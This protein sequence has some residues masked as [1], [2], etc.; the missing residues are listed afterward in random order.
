M[1]TIKFHGG[2]WHVYIQKLF[3]DIGFKTEVRHVDNNIVKIADTEFEDIIF[4]IQNSKISTNEVEKRNTHYNSCNKNVFWFVNGQDMEIMMLEKNNT[5]TFLIDIKSIWK[6]QKFINC[7]WIYA[8]VLHEG[9][10]YIIKFDPNMVKMNMIYV[11]YI[12]TIDYFFNNIKLDNTDILEKPKYIRPCSL[13]V[14]QYP[15]GSGKTFKMVQNILRPD[16]CPNFNQYDT[17]IILTKPHSAKEVVK[18][19]FESQLKNNVQDNIEVGEHNKGYWYRLRIQDRDILIILA[20]GDSF[21]YSVG[22]KRNYYLDYFK[23]IC[24]TIEEKGPSKLSKNGFTTFKGLGICI[25]AKTLICIDEATK[26]QDYYANALGKLMFYCN[27]DS[28]IIGDLLQS[29]EHEHSLFRKLLE[30]TDP[31][32]HVCKILENGNEIRR[33]GNNLVNFLVNINTV[34]TYNKYNLPRPIKCNDSNIKRDHEGKYE[35]YPKI[36]SFENK[37]ENEDQEIVDFL[38]DKLKE[39]I[40]TLFLLPSDVLCI[41]PFVSNNILAERFRDAL[42]IFWFEQLQDD[43]YRIHMLNSP[44]SSSAN[45]YFEWFDNK[46]LNKNM[47]LSVLHRSESGLP[48][49]TSLSRNSTR[50]VSIHASQ[51]DGRRFVFVVGLSE[52]TLKKFSDNEFN[53]KYDSLLNVACSRAKSECVIIIHKKYDDIFKRFQSFIS[54]SDKTEIKPC[55][56]LTSTIDMNKLSL[57]I[58]NLETDVNVITDKLKCIFNDNIQNLKPLY[59]YEHHVIRNSAYNLIWTMLIHEHDEQNSMDKQQVKAKFKQ[60]SE[61]PVQSFKYQQYYKTLTTYNKKKSYDNK[62]K[63]IYELTCIPVLF[64]SGK[65]YVHDLILKEVENAKKFFKGYSDNKI[66]FKHFKLLKPYQ[67]VIFWYVYSI[68]TQ[69]TECDVKMNT[70]YDIMLS[71]KSNTTLQKHYDYLEIRKVFQNV[72]K[73]IGIGE[74]KVFHEVFLD[75]N[76]SNKANIDKWQ[77]RLRLPYIYITNEYVSVIYLQPTIDEMRRESMSVLYAF[78]GYLISKPHQEDKGNNKDRFNQKKIRVIFVSMQEDNF[79][80]ID[81]DLNSNEASLLN[82]LTSNIYN[83]FSRQ[84]NCVLN[85]F[86]YYKSDAIDKYESQKH[87]VAYIK[88]CLSAICVEYE[89]EDDIHIYTHKLLQLLDKE[90]SKSLRKLKTNILETPFINTIV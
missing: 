15:P 44:Y 48:I 46:D 3:S 14:L 16:L 54:E 17:F 47:W 76:K 27:A 79:K 25:N 39:K 90:L 35:V 6:Y 4:E 45:E 70:L 40:K 61:L 66:I 78:S 37:S 2:L 21:I 57:L 29:I 67:I 88:N 58:P 60:I 53:L 38:L 74:W 11:T 56:H 30:D 22:E 51:G 72:V 84:H 69:R 49:D 20:T 28:I 36:S 83:N 13:S 62:Q 52:Y 85:F 77:C 26:F 80:C 32:P 18:S 86:K 55:I 1:S 81:W 24:K 87:K 63:T 82:I 42:D 9:V 33:F 5:K 41:F 73:Y 34:D 59:D 12:Y 8:Y 65:E 75:S 71:Y 43:E 50:L 68:I 89:D 19:E 23:D 7:G 64:Y 31:F 10:N